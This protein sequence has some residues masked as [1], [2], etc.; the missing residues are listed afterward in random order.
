MPTL[1]KCKL[2]IFPG[3]PAKANNSFPSSLTIFEYYYHRRQHSN[4]YFFLSENRDTKQL[5]SSRSHIFSYRLIM[6]RDWNI[7]IKLGLI[8]GPIAPQ[9]TALFVPSLSSVRHNSQS[10][11]DVLWSGSF[12]FIHAMY[13]NRAN[14]CTLAGTWWRIISRQECVSRDAKDSDLKAINILLFYAMDYL[15]RWE[16]PKVW[17]YI[18][19]RFA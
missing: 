11:N 3:N 15:H 2:S 16:T 8:L 14:A 5:W 10:N 19:F 7:W 1:Y 18:K 12:L 9:V 13:N 17:V 4:S 6:K